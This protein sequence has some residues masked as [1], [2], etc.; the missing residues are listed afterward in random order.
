[1]KS[2]KRAEIRDL[3][4][5]DEWDVMLNKDVIDIYQEWAG[6]TVVLEDIF[7]KLKRTLIHT[8]YL[9]FYSANCENVDLLKRY[10]GYCEPL[11]FFY[12]NNV[13]VHI[14]H[15]V[16][17]PNI[18]KAIEEQLNK[19]LQAMKG[20]QKREALNE[21]LL[22]KYAEYNGTQQT[23]RSSIKG[24]V[25]NDPMLY[26]DESSSLRSL[27][28]KTA[29]K[30]DQDYWLSSEPYRIGVALFVIKPDLLASGKKDEILDQLRQR[31]FVIHTQADKLL[32]NEDMMK[33][34]QPDQ[35]IIKEFNRFMSSGPSAYVVVSKGFTGRSTS[36]DL[37]SIIGYHDPDIAKTNHSESLTAIYG[38]DSIMNGF[39]SSA[40]NQEALK[41][42]QI[43]FPDY[44]YPLIDGKS[45][46]EYVHKTAT[47]C[48]LGP[49]Q[50]QTKKDAIIQ[51]I[52]KR[53][54]EI[55]Y[56][57]MYLFR[58]DEVE[59]L[60]IKHRNE[61]FFKT[62]IDAYT[63]GPCLL[64]YV[65]KENCVSD[66]NEFLGP[67]SREEFSQIPGTLRHDFD[68]PSTPVTTIHGSESIIDARKELEQFFSYQ[69]TLT[70]I[71]P[72]LT[73]NQKDDI[74]RRLKSNGFTIT[75]KE[76]RHLTKDILTQFYARHQGL[77][78][79]ND[80]IQFMSSDTCEILILAREN[81]VQAL[82]EI[83]G[84]VDPVRAKTDAPDSIR[85]IYGL[86]IM[87]NGLHASSNKKHA[88]EEIR[89]LFPDYIFLKT[90]PIPFHSNVSSIDA[91]VL[92]NLTISGENDLYHL[93]SHEI[94]YEFFVHTRL[95]ESKNEDSAV[96]ITLIGKDNETKKFLL[97]FSDNTIHPLQSN[98]IDI[99]HFVDR[100]VGIPKN[101]RLSHDGRG[102]PKNWIL[103]DVEITM[104]NRNKTYRFD[105]NELIDEENTKLNY[106]LTNTKDFEP[107]NKGNCV[108]IIQ[109]GSAKYANT[110]A[111]C[112]ILLSGSKGVYAFSL[113]QS[114]TNRLPFQNRY[115][116]IF[117]VE[118]DEHLK[119]IEYIVLEHNN[120]NSSPAWFV[121]FV[122]IKLL[123]NQQEYFFPVYR[124][125][126]IDYLDGK[127]KITLATDNQNIS[128]N[129]NLLED[130]SNLIRYEI[131]LVTGSMFDAATNCPVW[132]TINGTR[133]SI[134]NKYL[135]IAENESYPFEP[136]N[137]DLFI[138]YDVDIGEVCENK[139][140]NDRHESISAEQGWFVQSISIH[141]PSKQFHS[142]KFKINK[143]L[144]SK[145]IDAIPLIEVQV[146]K[147][148]KLRRNIKNQRTVVPQVVSNATLVSIHE[149]GTVALIFVQLFINKCYSY[150]DLESSYTI[151]ILTENFQ[152]DMNKLNIFI[153]LI[154]DETLS[155]GYMRLKCDLPIR[156]NIENNVLCKVQAFGKRIDRINAIR[157]LIRT[158]D[159]R[160]Y[161]FPRFI[162]ITVDETEEIFQFHNSKWLHYAN[163]NS[164]GAI[165]I[166][167]KVVS[168]ESVNQDSKKFIQSSSDNIE[169][170]KNHQIE[171]QLGWIKQSYT[172]ETGNTV[173]DKHLTK[174]NKD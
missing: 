23:T 72:G 173:I 70:I 28:L 126:S 140:T 11:L 15:Q 47:L 110:F 133:G 115:R 131:H 48:L 118:V 138:L 38:T 117:L 96:F 95:N 35:D 30:I 122:M 165:T 157:L 136:A 5:N 78:W 3:H 147:P 143:W 62:L 108:I 121:D 83:M 56:K 12:G 148:I 41:D 139:A 132:L 111:D 160:T 104:T 67:F 162:L 171:N 34:F 129:E 98:K 150:L 26:K 74:V 64:L 63:A 101:I 61:E 159:Q 71:K 46:D 105:I 153:D 130:R 18:E 109:T 1:M 116:D 128:Y 161:W 27:L 86:D 107:M 172:K 158:P 40:N 22:T 19:E 50:V 58:P 8:E 21:L 134:I 88:R 43:V 167:L 97:Q 127:T 42:I 120:E 20:N 6:A 65:A 119:Q 44:Q 73:M 164:F 25:S 36:D 13:L 69:Q 85:A 163:S 14:E 89:L 94:V 31:G 37:R 87:R 9:T 91:T 106:P 114:L 90:K 75:A 54:F 112:S 124:W 68:E 80:F 144:N 53:G 76:T 93:E 32:D 156:D 113:H 169:Q 141:I 166:Y 29:E 49:I 123:N 154:M 151:Y 145:R 152:S 79:F 146:R 59:S 77:P 84:P 57:R 66:F 103:G 60:Y 7:L 52:V 17:V 102:F 149:Y 33:I 137:D 39:Y 168:L 82:R 10:R 55:R 170:K 16:N 142:E 155:T 125:L 92:T 99:F 4:S 135:E 100:D 24:S 2:K 51:A 81:A 174:Q 45:T